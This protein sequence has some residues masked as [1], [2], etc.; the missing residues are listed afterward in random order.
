[1]SVSS[2]DRLSR[3]LRLFKIRPISI[4]FRQSFTRRPSIL[5]PCWM[6]LVGTLK[7]GYWQPSKVCFRIFWMFCDVETKGNEL[8]RSR[9]IMTQL[10]E[11][12]IELRPGQCT[13]P[14]ASDTNH[15]V[16]PHV[17]STSGCQGRDWLFRY[18]WQYAAN[19]GGWDII[20]ALAATP[21]TLFCDCI[22]FWLNIEGNDPSLNVLKRYNHPANTYNSSWWRLSPECLSVLRTDVSFLIG[23]HFYTPQYSLPARKSAVILKM[24]H[25]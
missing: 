14:V 10:L 4:A 7:K 20:S 6:S 12:R 17:I 3:P 22:W 25:R 1:M 13:P 23:L 9:K 21:A 16:N 18:Y 2:R 5:P 19:T 8:K 24:I 15:Q 11:G